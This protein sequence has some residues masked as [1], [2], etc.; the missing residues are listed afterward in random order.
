MFL[1]PNINLNID[2]Y[3]ILWVYKHFSNSLVYK[4][5]IN[6]FKCFTKSEEYLYLLDDDVSTAILRE[7][8]EIFLLVYLAVSLLFEA[9]IKL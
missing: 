2:N 8:G 9:I 6:V 1:K 4:C 3:S 7:T 5:L